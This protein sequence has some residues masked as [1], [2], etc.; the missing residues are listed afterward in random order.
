MLQPL[1][2]VMLRNVRAEISVPLCRALV[3]VPICLA[4]AVAGLAGT[5]LAFVL[6]VR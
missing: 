4:G 1:K 2:D 3:L 6:T 5:L